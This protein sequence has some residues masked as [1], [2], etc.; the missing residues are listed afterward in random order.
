M[1]KASGKDRGPGPGV[2]PGEA[3]QSSPQG[4]L[5]PFLVPVLFPS[6]TQSFL[7]LQI[8]F[9]SESSHKPWVP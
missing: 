8:S 7:L 4:H 5:E 3:S 1:A 6:E 2:L 9:S